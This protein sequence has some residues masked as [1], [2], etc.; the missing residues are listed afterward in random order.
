VKTQQPPCG[1]GAK[2]RKAKTL[3]NGAFRESLR[4]CKGFFITVLPKITVQEANS[5][6][7][8]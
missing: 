7:G 6:A 1:K 4:L 2:F 8:Y 3:K 5:N